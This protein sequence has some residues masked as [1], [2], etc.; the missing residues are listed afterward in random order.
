M[1]TKTRTTIITL[2][3]AFSFAG[4]A[5]VPAVSHASPKQAP[6]QTHAELCQSYEA[7][8]E[9]FEEGAEDPASSASLKASSHKQ[10][11]KVARTA[12]KAGCDTSAWRELP[13]ETSRPILVPPGTVMQ[14]APEAVTPVRVMATLSVK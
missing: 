11:A 12:I 8:F 3:A 7:E 1:L 5:M 14:G 10:A 2:V 6:K 9:I 13:P 4:A